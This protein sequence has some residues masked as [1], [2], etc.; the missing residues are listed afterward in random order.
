MLVELAISVDE[1]ECVTH[2]VPDGSEEVVFAVGGAVGGGFVSCVCQL[3]SEL[4]AIEGGGVDVPPLAVGIVVDGDGGG[5]G[6][7]VRVVFCNGGFG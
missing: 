3:G 7:A 4:A 5:F 2:F 6:S 1:A